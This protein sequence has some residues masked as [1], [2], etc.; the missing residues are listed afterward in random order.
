MKYLALII[1]VL[2][3]TNVNASPAGECNGTPGSAITELP[4]PLSNWGQILCTP[5]GHIITNQEGWIWTSPGSYSP[6]MIP[7]QM[8]RANPE[9][10]GNKS[11]FTKIEMVYLTGKEAEDSIKLFEEGF[12]TSETKPKVYSLE[13]VSISGK[14]LRFRFYDYGNFQ[15]GMWCKKECDPN[16][17]FMM[18][19][20]AGTSR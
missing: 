2:L 4:Q 8:V 18:L 10:L 19:N 12:D 17:K 20:M 9:S 14:K 7:S 16:S 13:V 5:Y 3:S 1:M 6:V 11:Y 15:W